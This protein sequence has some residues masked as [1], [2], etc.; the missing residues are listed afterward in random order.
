MVSL[1]RLRTELRVKPTDDQGPV[2]VAARERAREHLR[3]GRSF[4]WNAINVSRRLRDQAIGLV[5]DYHGRVDLVA[6][7]A[8]PEILRR[9]NRA[10]EHPVPDAVIDRLASRWE[11]PDRTEAH[12]LTYVVTG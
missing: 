11:A 3:A 8:S 12:D 9:R 2:V 10:R 6:I 1:D 7:E 5:A 4:V